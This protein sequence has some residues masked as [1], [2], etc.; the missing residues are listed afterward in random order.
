MKSL[1]ALIIVDLQNDFVP[2]GALAVKEGDHIIPLINHLQEKFDLIVAS[3]DWHPPNHT[4]FASTHGKLSGEVVQFNGRDQVL[5]P[6]HCVQHSW[7]ADFVPGLNRDKMDEIFFKGVEENIDSYSAISDNAKLRST[8]L[9]EYL[10]EKNIKEIYIVGLATDYCIKYT[11]ID[12]CE[13]GFNTHVVIDACRGIELHPG[14]I[15]KS[16]QEM[17]AAGA[18]LIESSSINAGF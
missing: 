13:K 17:S 9:S 7:G 11:A 10:I 18:K 5:W 12:A 14:D 4:S 8:G 2:G 6:I 1:R 3:K 15:L 16:F